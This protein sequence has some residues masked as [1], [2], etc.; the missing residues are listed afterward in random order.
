MADKKLKSLRDLTVKQLR[1]EAVKLGMPKADA[2][3]FD[4]K[5]PLVATIKTL[6]IAQAPKEEVKKVKTLT[7]PADP[8]EEKKTE[9]QWKT[10][11][12]R[13]RAKL[14]A[15]PKIRFM[16]PIEGEEKPGVVREVMVKGRKEYV[17]VSGAIETVT[18]NGC[19]TI[20]PKGKF[21]EIPQQVA[22]VLSESYRLTQ[23][24]GKEFLVD[25]IDPT[26]GKQVK[27]ALS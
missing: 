23:E 10:K 1:E 24:A 2:E 5:A 27:D 16:I 22:D 8:K 12:Q 7:P 18:L 15:Q 6:R 20:I 13:M 3:T 9:E 14:D 25:R 11:A 4:K 26:T 17:H 21:I 19:K